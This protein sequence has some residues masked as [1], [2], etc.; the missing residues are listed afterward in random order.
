MTLLEQ[1]R[2]WHLNGE[3]QK[4]ADAIE[5]IPKA[6]W[7]PDMVSE[8]A[9]AYNNIAEVGDHA[10]FEHV[11]ELLLSVENELHDDHLW[12]FRLGYA[13]FYLD[14]EGEALESFQRALQLLPDAEDTKEMIRRCQKSL[15]LPRFPKNFRTRV[16]EAWQAF[17]QM[18]AQ[19][20]EFIDTMGGDRD[21]QHYIDRCSEALKHA[22]HS[23]S[24]E[25]G[26]GEDRYELVLTPEGDRDA[27]E[28]LQYFARRI[29][30]SLKQWRIVVGRTRQDGR[31]FGLRID[32]I[33]ITPQ[34]I[35]VVYRRDPVAE[36]LEFE[37][38]VYSEKLLPVLR[39]HEGRAW[40]VISTCIDHILGEIAAIRY[41]RG[42]DL[43]IEP[44]TE[45]SIPLS[46]LPEALKAEGVDLDAT[47]ADYLENSYVG[48]RFEPSDDSPR[49]DVIVGTTRC[50]VLINEYLSG[51]TH[52]MNQLHRDGI[53]AGFIYY[54]LDTFATSEKYSEDVLNF[55]EQ[56]QEAILN[57]AGSDAVYFHGG[58]TGQHF[59]Y[60][61]F[62]AWDL[63]ST[64]SAAAKFLIN[65]PLRWSVF[66][67]FRPGVEGITLHDRE[68]FEETGQLMQ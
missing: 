27:V 20:R 47:A 37:L 24:F 42:L 54:P 50:P 19:L 36:S 15:A 31:T 14:R 44:H 10:T 59:G 68:P 3:F 21:P 25:L 64:L 30:N 58:A 63:R 12:N 35:Q 61:D 52:F 33:D 5:A 32:E 22:F 26:K 45:Q 51:E 6:E 39:S 34:D 55:R 4:I 11:V 7:T 56:L 66:Q 60:L 16:Q 53:V 62:V 18:E 40:W 57:E 1:C 49:Y 2:I 29:P 17:T 9:R 28:R 38:I 43:R 67:V 13:Y 23:I 41:I 46:E 8:L 48:Y 65:T